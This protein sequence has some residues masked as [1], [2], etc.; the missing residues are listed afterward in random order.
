M[1]FTRDE[2]KE[3]LS[4]PHPPDCSYHDEVWDDAASS[5]LN[6]QALTVECQTCHAENHLLYEIDGLDAESQTRFTVETP[7][8]WIESAPFV[9]F[10]SGGETGCITA[11]TSDPS[12]Y[13]DTLWVGLRWE[14]PNSKNVGAE[15]VSLERFE[16]W[17]DT[18]VLVLKPE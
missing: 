11:L 12:P 9:R 5:R 1:H 4:C 7:F 18:G 16:S 17:I 6:A 15:R 13:I 14:I 10:Q 3:R 2:A 8:E